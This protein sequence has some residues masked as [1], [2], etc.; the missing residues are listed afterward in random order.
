[1]KQIITISTLFMAAFGLLFY[2]CYPRTGQPINGQPERQLSS[3]DWSKQGISFIDSHRYEEAIKAL[4]KALEINPRNA[5]AYYNRGYAWR[6]NGDLMQAL[7]DF[8]MVL[9]LM[10]NN[11]QVKASVA[12]LENEIMWEK[13]GKKYFRRR[14][15]DS[16]K[17]K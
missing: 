17:N 14:M 6:M 8:K 2:G 11:K 3:E 12:I 10:P 7:A 5:E 16:T 4:T 1:M 13:T 9:S 15:H